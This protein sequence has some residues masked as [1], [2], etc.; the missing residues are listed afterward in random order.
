MRALPAALFGG[1]DMHF[2]H[3]VSHSSNHPPHQ[4]ASPKRLANR[5]NGS[6]RDVVLKVTVGKADHKRPCRHGA[7]RWSCIRACPPWSDVNPRGFEYRSRG[8]ALIPANPPAGSGGEAVD[9]GLARYVG[10]LPLLH[11]PR[12]HAPLVVAEQR[13]TQRQSVPAIG[14]S[15]RRDKGRGRQLR[16]GSSRRPTPIRRGPRE[17]LDGQRSVAEWIEAGHRPA[18]RSG[19]RFSLLQVAE[20]SGC[21]VTRHRVPRGRMSVPS[22]SSRRGPLRD[23][24]DAVVSADQHA[25]TRRHG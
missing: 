18:G 3:A 23:P 7:P 2:Q 11:E 20:T 16:S 19:R 15:D 12:S 17:H 13:S 25:E 21:K 6:P 22:G 5:W 24:P 4:A 10:L 8:I 1:L 9:G 14:P